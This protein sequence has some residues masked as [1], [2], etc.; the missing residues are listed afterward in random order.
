MNKVKNSERPSPSSLFHLAGSK[1]EHVFQVKRQRCTFIEW[2]QN[3]QIIPISP[4]RLKDRYTHK[5]IK[6]TKK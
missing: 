5:L 4:Q 2:L 3:K 1:N 6:Q